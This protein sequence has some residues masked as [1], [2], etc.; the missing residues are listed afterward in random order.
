VQAGWIGRFI[1]NTCQNLSMINPYLGTLTTQL[2][3][4]EIEVYGGLKASVSK[5]FNFSTTASFISY[6]NFPF[7][8]NDTAAGSSGNV[9]KISND[10]KVSDFRVHADMSF[11]SQDKFTIT[12]GL[13]YNGYTGLQ[14]NNKAWGMIPLQLNA[15]LRWWAYKQVL[16]KSDF[17]TFSSTEYLLPGNISR[18]LKGG[19][20]LSAGVE[21][22]ITPKINAW[23]DIN[24]IFNDKYQ[25]WYNYEVYGI[26]FL[27][28][29]IFKF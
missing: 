8:I 24:N 22:V 13:T 29:V 3:T 26:N 11:I 17:M 14:G 10:S 21:V 28:G 2:N 23:F 12:G 20:D 7:F 19:A 6:D 1:K 9:F 4:K 5:H 16:I 18:S 27:A 15:S 25:R